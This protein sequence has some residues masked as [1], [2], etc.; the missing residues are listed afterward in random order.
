MLPGRDDVTCSSEQ[1]ETFVSACHIIADRYGLVKCSSGNLSMRVGEDEMLVSASRSWMADITVDQIAHMR[2]SDETVLNGK[3]PSVESRFHAGVLK[4]RS[5]VNVVLHFQ[6]PAATAVC[7]M[8]ICDLNFAVTP[9]VPYYIGSVARVPYLQP[10][11]E[12]LACAVIGALQ[13]AD[14][15][16]LANHGQVTVGKNIEDA[17]QKAVFFEMACE[18]LLRLEERAC[19]LPDNAIQTLVDQGRGRVPGKV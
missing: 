9:E 11:S 15:A 2:I 13:D 14:M 7:C 3:T 18:I 1:L 4:A 5:E 12:E 17:L 6:S 19:P 10:G 16:V 8:D